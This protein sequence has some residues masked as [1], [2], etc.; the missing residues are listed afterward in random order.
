MHTEHTGADLNHIMV[1][2]LMGL[3]GF[4]IDIR[5]SF[6]GQ[7]GEKVDRTTLLNGGMI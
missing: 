3:D 5:A 7:I 6:V 1:G 4:P 2:K